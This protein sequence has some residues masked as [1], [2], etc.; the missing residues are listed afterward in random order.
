MENNESCIYVPQ[1]TPTIEEMMFLGVDGDTPDEDVAAIN[2]L[3]FAT[4]DWFDGDLTT[5]EYLDLVNDT[6]KTGSQNHL[7]RLDRILRSY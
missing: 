6:L 4:S 3:N 1:F 7:D 5:G 2:Q